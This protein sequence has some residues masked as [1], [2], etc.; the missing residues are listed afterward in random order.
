MAK[1]R[2]K[3]ADR[4]FLKNKSAETFQKLIVKPD[5]VFSNES[6]FGLIEALITSL[7]LAIGASG[8]S[9]LMAHQGRQAQRMAVKYQ[10]LSHQDA[11]SKAFG[12][13]QNCSWIMD[14]LNLPYLP[15]YTD[16]SSHFHSL[17]SIPNPLGGDLVT[18]GA[19]LPRL[20]DTGL[21]NNSLPI[22][23]EDIRLFN[24]GIVKQ[25]DRGANLYGAF[26]GTLRIDLAVDP[27]GSSGTAGAVAPIEVSNVFYFRNG[28]SGIRGCMTHV[29][30]FEDT[31]YDDLQDLFARNTQTISESIA[32]AE[33]A[34]LDIQGSHTQFS[35]DMENYVDSQ[36]T[37]LR[38][39]VLSEATTDMEN[40]Q[41]QS[42]VAMS[43]S[44]SSE[45]LQIENHLSS[46]LAEMRQARDQAIAQIDLRADEIRTQMSDAADR[47]VASTRQ[48]LFAL[49]PTGAPVTVPGSGGG[50]GS[51]EGGGNTCTASGNLHLTSIPHYTG[52]T[53]PW[54]VEAQVQG[55]SDMN[56]YTIFVT[57]PNATDSAS[58][59]NGLPS[60]VNFS[61]DPGPRPWT[62]TID[63]VDNNN[64]KY[65][66]TFQ[67]SIN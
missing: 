7:V 46:V 50:D 11:I 41:I 38:N 55:P 28:S 1:K 8:F 9:T 37:D 10:V 12:D 58:A 14:T 60:R 53:Y 48:R 66:Q 56:T 31:F 42:E 39:R 18:R 21:N 29:I 44:A 27:N 57:A 62:F 32:A 19:A 17:A 3:I 64:C 49:A 13:P 2:S 16:G 6:G 24:N 20:V 4:F 61:S 30:D 22:F 40:Q 5:S 36:I 34:K 63:A 54:S 65:T 45:I 59:A 15:V 51:T 67:G 43:A 33:Q 35:I 25:P 23:V 47:H 52:S 26:R